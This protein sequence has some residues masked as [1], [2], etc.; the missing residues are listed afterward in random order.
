MLIRHSVKGLKIATDAIFEAIT[1][2]GEQLDDGTSNRP[3]RVK[4]TQ[5]QVHA[6]P[7]LE[8]MATH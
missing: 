1:F 8:P 4:D 6:L 2:I 7:H 5:K 3:I